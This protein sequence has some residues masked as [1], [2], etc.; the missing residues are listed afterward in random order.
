MPVCSRRAFQAEKRRFSGLRWE[1]L[2]LSEGQ[3]E[4]HG[5][6]KDTVVGDEVREVMGA[7]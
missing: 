7:P 6:N 4:G 3:Q 2:G 1:L 5:A